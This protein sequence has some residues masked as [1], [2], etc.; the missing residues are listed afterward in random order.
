MTGPEKRS[1]IVAA[2]PDPLSDRI[3][4]YTTWP[5]L[6]QTVGQKSTRLLSPR[7]RSE[8]GLRRASSKRRGRAGRRSS[9]SLALFP[10]PFR[11]R[12]PLFPLL[13]PQRLL[14]W[15]ETCLMIAGVRWGWKATSLLEAR[16]KTVFNVG[17]FVVLCALM[18]HFT[19]PAA[20]PTWHLIQGRLPGKRRAG[21]TRF[22]EL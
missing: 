10:S 9:S 19:S 17:G 21:H 8:I 12:H 18:M 7:A 13:P 6:T 4:K 14:A 3:K 1:R 20:P 15:P 11:P 5:G 2:L 16:S 22:L